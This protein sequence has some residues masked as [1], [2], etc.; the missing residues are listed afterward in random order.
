MLI[1]AI[2]LRRTPSS[3]LDVPLVQGQARKLRRVPTPLAIAILTFLAIA[4][5]SPNNNSSQVVTRLGLTLSIVERGE[6]N[7]DRFAKITTD[8]ALF[9]G[10]Y[11]A[12]KAPGLSLL[13]VPAVA[14][15][16]ALLQNYNPRVESS[17]GFVYRLYSLAA[18]LSVN[19]LLSALAAAGIY[20]AARRLGA[21]EQAAIFGS[22]AIAAGSPF[23]GWS[24]TF[25]A[26]S[27]S[28]S[29][30][31]ILLLL[32]AV[33]L[34]DRRLPLPARPFLSALLIGVLAGIA[35][36]IDFTTAPPL[37]IG[38]VL[39]LFSA[40]NIATGRWSFLAGLALGGIVGLLPLPIYNY[41][42]FGSPLH[43]GYSS[44]VGFAGMQQGL[45]GVTWPNP[46]VS[47]L[48]LLGPQRG[49]L[50]LC[51]L[52]LFAIPGFRHMYR[53]PRTRPS[54]IIIAA[55]ALSFFWLNSSYHYWNGG[56]STGPRHMVPMLPLLGVALAFAWP[57]K[58]LAWKIVA[59][60]LLAYGLVIGVLIAGVNPFARSSIVYPIVKILLPGLFADPLR[61]APILPI[62]AGFGWLFWRA[63]RQPAAAP[64]SDMPAPTG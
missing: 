2:S 18:V 61:L 15:T 39:M 60:V 25:F 21:S 29:L 50:L 36:V 33:A 26:H 45:F 57:P 1:G 4:V 47:V 12:D 59:I 23:L 52:L 32:T 53:E 6:L 31:L 49:L 16:R 24:T 9:E 11:Y 35:I 30:L 19:A 42:A 38:G 5:F 44:V 51:P 46:V 40:R 13:G 56:S 48:L 8:K 58:T 62:W 54:A 55:T 27:V 22:F 64:A 63:G 41:L 3:G 34:A 17:D 43:L 7:I 14:A 20:V 10:H 28:G 37:L